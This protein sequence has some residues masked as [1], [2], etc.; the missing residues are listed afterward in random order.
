MSFYLGSLSS[1]IIPTNDFESTKD[2]ECNILPVAEEHISREDIGSWSTKKLLRALDRRN[3]RYS[4]TASRLDLEDTFLRSNT[5]SIDNLQN[6][7]DICTRNSSARAADVSSRHVDESAPS[8]WK[9]RLMKRAHRRQKRVGEKLSSPMPFSQNQIVQKIPRIV[10]TVVDGVVRKA[11][12]LK[13]HVSDVWALDDETGVRDVRYEYVR[14][15]TI[16]P[17]MSPVEVVPVEHMDVIVS[18]PSDSLTDQTQ[19]F[20]SFDKSKR[21]RRRSSAEIYVGE[22][23][24]YFPSSR[25][26]ND[27]GSNVLRNDNILMLPPGSVYDEIP[28]DVASRIR[29]NRIRRPKGFQTST[30]KKVYNPYGSPIENEKDVVDRISEFLAV[31]ADRVMWGMFD[32]ANDIETSSESPNF[33]SHYDNHDKPREQERSQRQVRPKRKPPRHWKDRM[34]ERL[35]SLL[36]L[37]QDSDFYRSWTER[38]EREKKKR[39]QNE[40]SVSTQSPRRKR[41]T[42][43]SHSK[44]IWEETGSVFSLLFGRSEIGKS[45]RF[46]DGL[47]FETGSML[48]VFRVILRSFLTVAS[49]L[50]RWASTQG[51]LPQPV[52]VFGV[53]SAVLCARPHRRLMVAGIA[54][55]MLRT[56][57]EVLHGYVHGTDGWE[58]DFDSEDDNADYENASDGSF[59][60]D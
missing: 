52:V 60:D 35:D 26:W 15:E 50:C 16:P 22:D 36:G 55:L 13:R 49:Y 38:F 11:R 3:T 24:D 18:D 31:T 37:H 17:P 9:E 20:S 25:N 28:D 21:R 5:I 43:A 7:E 42:H 41:Q 10:G 56:V 46:D 40:T 12:R 29:R 58:N 4:P 59:W 51:A 30:D 54:L 48:S 53:S 23:G 47:G 14:R 33:S 19:T 1:R 8:E 39:T 45:R 6:D 34:E 2:H 44:P 57:G 27:E 32:E